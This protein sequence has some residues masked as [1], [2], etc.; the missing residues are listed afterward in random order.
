MLLCHGSP[1]A[2]LFAGL[3]TW[4]HRRSRPVRVVRFSGPIFLLSFFLLVTSFWQPYP[5]EHGQVLGQ[6]YQRVG[7]DRAC[8]RRRR[9]TNARKG[10]VARQPETL[11]RCLVAG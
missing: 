10:K 1:F 5:I 2:G 4:R 6:G 3:R 7:G 11:E 9:N 8:G